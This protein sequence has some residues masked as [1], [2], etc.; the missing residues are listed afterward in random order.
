LF[1]TVQ[2]LAQLEAAEV[3]D[4]T[5]TPSWGYHRR[6]QNTL[7]AFASEVYKE[8][9]EDTAEASFYINCCIKSLNEALIVPSVM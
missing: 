8:I 9:R 3:M 1:K 4:I 6:C 5:V 7:A 2:I